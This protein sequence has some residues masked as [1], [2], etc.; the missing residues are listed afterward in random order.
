MRLRRLVDGTLGLPSGLDDDASMPSDADSNIEGN[1]R[2]R[3]SSSASSASTTSSTR[4]LIHAAR[5]AA[6]GPRKKAV[7]G[8][9]QS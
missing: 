9:Q 1:K 5:V 6:G 7:L 3:P 4:Q 2:E 8:L